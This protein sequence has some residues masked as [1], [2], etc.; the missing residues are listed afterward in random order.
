MLH[1]VYWADVCWGGHVIFGAMKIHLSLRL[2]NATSLIIYFIIT[3]I[4]FITIVIFII[5]V[6][7]VFFCYFFHYCLMK[8][9]WNQNDNSMFWSFRIHQEKNIC[10]ALL[11][12]K[13]YHK[14]QSD[15]NNFKSQKI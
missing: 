4:V 5:V 10:W 3:I 12:H 1:G 13:S 8:Y 9:S 11:Q 6:V 15:R 2:E 14:H 7:D